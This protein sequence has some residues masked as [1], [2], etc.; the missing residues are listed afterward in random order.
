M[1]DCLDKIGQCGHLGGEFEILIIVG[2]SSLLLA[3]YHTKECDLRLYMK[4]AK[5]ESIGRQC[6]SMPSW[7]LFLGLS[8]L[9]GH[10]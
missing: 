2:G 5:H 4:L 9:L 3:V 8:E 10:K 7:F 1:R 6:N